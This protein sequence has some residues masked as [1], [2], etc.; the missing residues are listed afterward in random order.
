MAEAFLSEQQTVVLILLECSRRVRI[1]IS[2]IYIIA[3]FPNFALTGPFPK[4]VMLHQQKP[5]HSVRR[6]YK[7][8]KAYW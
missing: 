7:F 6:R 4:D 5:G 1:F 8:K 3:L 2:S